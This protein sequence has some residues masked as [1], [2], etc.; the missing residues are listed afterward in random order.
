MFQKFWVNLE[1]KRYCI[2]TLSVCSL[3]AKNPSGSQVFNRL[4]TDF[5]AIRI[6]EM[7]KKML[8]ITYNMKYLKVK[9]I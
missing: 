6:P 5:F 7:K 4:K 9:M 3:N 8:R 2:L 1:I